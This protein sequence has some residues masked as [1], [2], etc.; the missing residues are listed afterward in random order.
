M[1]NLPKV[2]VIIPVYGVEKYIERCVRS[3]FEQTLDSIEYLFIDDCTPDNSIEIMKKTLEDYPNRK[4]QV[5]IHRM[6]KNSG[7]A[8]VREWGMKHVR[9]E[10]VTHCDSDDW[11]DINMYQEMYDKAKTGNYD[12][13]RC[14]FVRTDGISETMCN[15]IQESC[16]GHA[17]QLISKAL[18]G[19]SLTSLCD[20]LVSRRILRNIIY[21]VDNMYEDTVIVIQML[22]YAK[23]IGYISKPFYKYCYSPNSICN[24]IEIGSYINRFY[25]VCAN[26]D[27]IIKFLASNSIIDDYRKEIEVLKYRAKS[28]LTDV[29]N[30]R[31]CYILWRKSYPEITNR[32]LFNKKMRWQDK[33]KFYACIFKIYGALSAFFK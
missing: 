20:K 30:H 14:N 12:I 13:V 33:I 29:L 11:V 4:G 32:L 23:K 28:H 24:N 5:L 7:Q 26:T 25:Q 9:G 2:S 31:E 1:M 15:I 8:A 3:L 22:Y 16:Y 17:D 10:Y 6:D 21:P 18:I 27:L 19:E